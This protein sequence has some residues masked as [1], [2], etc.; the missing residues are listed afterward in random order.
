M[1]IR[2][3]LAFLKS[4]S[5]RWPEAFFFKTGDRRVL[6]SMNDLE[7]EGIIGELGLSRI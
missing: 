2:L 4:T 7:V 1:I 5:P 3:T 6:G